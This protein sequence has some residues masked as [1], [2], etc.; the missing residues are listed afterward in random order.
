MELNELWTL[1]ERRLTDASKLLTPPSEANGMARAFAV[2]I[3]A[4]ILAC[5]RSGELD[6]L[7]DGDWVDLSHDFSD[8][9]IYWP[10]AKPF[11]L[12]VVSAQ[13]TDAGYYYAANNFSAA[14]HGGTHLD[15][16]IHFAE[17]RWT[18]DQIPIQRLVGQAVV[19]DVQAGADSSA[20]YRVDNT[21]IAGWERKH[22]AI[23]SGSIV[24]F[25]TGWAR[26]WPDRAAYLGTSRAGAAAV[27]NLHFPG[28]DSATAQ[29][30]VNRNVKAVGIDTP[31]IDYGQSTSF[32][33]HRVLFAANI[34]AFEN[35]ANLDRL[36]PRG[37]FVIALPMKIKGGSG[38][39][40]RIVA[41]V[42]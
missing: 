32:P 28:I 10:T 5:G 42:P 41:L 17:G 9:T 1:H 30:L 6:V 38:G 39:P 31:S 3:L 4:G 20:D 37:S 26:R 27:A 16:P 33:T 19:V 34:P 14:E 25:R 12:E 24:L 13:Q 23:P 15:A 8:Q 35:V 7:H 11:E 29:W 36:P 2:L 22:G 21:A 18:T 40:L